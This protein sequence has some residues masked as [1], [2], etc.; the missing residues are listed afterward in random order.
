MTLGCFCAT[1]AWGKRVMVLSGGG[2][3]DCLLDGLA[4]FCIM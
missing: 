4:M 3:V 1:V 2:E